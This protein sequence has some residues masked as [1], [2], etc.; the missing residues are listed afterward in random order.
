MN[1]VYPVAEPGRKE[2]PRLSRQ[3]RRSEA[4]GRATDEVQ[5]EHGLD[6]APPQIPDWGEEPQ[7]TGICLSGGGIRSASYCLGALQ[8]LGRDGLLFGNNHARYLAAVS[9]GSYIAT[10]LTMVTKGRLD[11]DDPTPNDPTVTPIRERASNGPDL[12]PFAHGS[13]EEGYL[14]DH[15]LYLTHGRAGIPAVA[16][17]I[18]LG[19][20]FNVAMVTLALSVAFVPVGWLYG[21]GWPQLKAGCPSSC[22]S[23]PRFGVPGG[24]WVTV[25]VLA[26]LAFLT[27]FM[28][29]AWR[30]HA[31]WM[32]SVWGT[33]SGSLAVATVVILLFSVAIPWIIHLARPYYHVHLPGDAHATK[34]TTVAIT[35]A[36]LLGVVAA[37]VATARRL[38]AE[39]N[40]AAHDAVQET[41]GFAKKH[42]ALFVNIGAT[43]AGPLLVLAGV[44]ILSF[45]GSAYLPNS[46]GPGLAELLAW[47]GAVVAFLLLW[48]RADVT[49][50]SLFPL[51]RNRLSAG[52][53]LRRVR[54]FENESPSPTA[55]GDQ[56]AQERSY[57]Q[58]YPLSAY[59][60]QDFPEVIICAAANISDYGATPSG[61][62]VTSFTFSSE[63][64][65]GPVVGARPTVEYEEACGI[66]TAQA[67]FTTLPTAMAI[68]AAAFSPSMGRM[69]RAPFRFFLALANL[70]LGVW[71]PNPRRLDKFRDRRA[72]HQV[73]PRPQYF[74]REM[75][76]RNHLDAPFLYVTDGG[77][78]ENLGLVEL[79]RRKCE[80][81]WCID[82]SGDQVNTFN[83]LGGALQTAQAELQVTVE[84][85][86][87]SDMEPQAAKTDRR[88]QFVEQP[89]C[90]GKITYADGTTGSLRFVKAGVP[91]DAP[92]S[93]RAFAE[94]NP[95]FPCDATLDQFY[96][97]AR[98]DAYR[99]LGELSVELA[100]AALNKTGFE[101][102]P[103]PSPG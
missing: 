52:F 59:Q 103:I 77:H 33:L 24:L 2:L 69:T 81:I 84:I 93:L 82:A 36:G 73:L 1:F 15:T 18:L 26:V 95:A 38:L 22:P 10:A 48:A 91:K 97:A 79:L 39:P 94:S 76:G 3:L 78:Y 99:E 47:S 87:E 34:T 13:P 46:S 8:G 54:R 4:Q 44:V 27:G 102:P 37:W 85:N 16:W 40:T 32:R 83:T 43:I 57:S 68:S 90:Q 55:V 9:G 65:G 17:R 98:F 66:S 53:V 51:Y 64:I 80:T 63:W 92:L 75:F 19:I 11:E 49:A 60:P 41:I 7:G 45:W 12:T 89:W 74:L 29:L 30:F 101:N 86:P 61:S 20:T 42:Q 62:H 88:P 100:L 6:H 28:W 56:D 21:L 96:D 14:R 67:R 23:G 25:V 58:P 72:W 70:R 5:G 50:W 35:G 31:D 71:V